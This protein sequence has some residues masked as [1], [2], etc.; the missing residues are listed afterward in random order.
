[1]SATSIISWILEEDRHVKSKSLETML[2]LKGKNSNKQKKEGKG[3]KDLSNIKCYKCN[4]KGHYARDCGKPKKRR[5]M[6]KQLK[7]KNQH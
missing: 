6:K 5:E 2:N 3:K 7:W 4:K 1:M